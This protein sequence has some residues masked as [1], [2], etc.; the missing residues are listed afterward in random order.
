MK[1]RAI[2]ITVGAGLIFF[3]VFVLVKEPAHGRENVGVVCAFIRNAAPIL[4]L[5]ACVLISLAA[6]KMRIL[7]LIGLV[8]AI[9]SLV[10]GYFVSERTGYSMGTLGWTTT[11][12]SMFVVIP[13]S[14]IMCLTTVLASLIH[15]LEKEPT[16]KKHVFIA[17][18][19]ILMLGIGYNFTADYKP[20]VRRL[21]EAI[22]K[23]ENKY[24]RFSLAARISEINDDEKVP[25]LIDLLQDKNPRVREA[26]AVALGGRPRKAKA[27]AVAPLIKAFENETDKEARKWIVRALF[28]VAA[29][30][31]QADKDRA[32]D[33]LIEILKD[34]S[35]RLRGL[36]AEGLGWMKDER[37]IEPLIDA[38][39][40]E[41]FNTYNALL[42]IT[43]QR[44][45]RNPQT[46][47][48]WW[49]KKKG[50]GTKSRP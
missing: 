38:L 46:W 9:G 3:S 32:V 41:P 1:L 11:F 22:K 44:L 7:S 39:V 31:D 13:L 42:T 29:Q 43:G 15:I 17:A 16:V 34:K 4:M 26:A 50:T 8:C 49:E 48:E 24:K 30:A 45:D 37:A 18:L 2:L 35:S 23:D 33:F 14:L 25:Y 27:K 36:A 12:I 19:F 10:I 28:S 47:K 20:D 21:I 6:V 5:A 40:D